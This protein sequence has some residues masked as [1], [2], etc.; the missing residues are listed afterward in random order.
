[1]DMVNSIFLLMYVCRHINSPGYFYLKIQTMISK[2]AFN[3]FIRLINY[4]YISTLETLLRFSGEFDMLKCNAKDIRLQ[5][6]VD[7]MLK[8]N[9]TKPFEHMYFTLS[10]EQIPCLVVNE[11]RTFTKNVIA[12]DVLKHRLHFTIPSIDYL[13][14]VNNTRF[15]DIDNVINTDDIER[16][17]NE[18]MVKHCED[19]NETIDTLNF[20][21]IAHRDIELLVPNNV[22]TKCIVTFN[23]LELIDLFRNGLCFKH[24]QFMRST[25]H[26]IKDTI[27]TVTSGMFDSVGPE[28][29]KCILP[30][31]VECVM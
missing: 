10:I 28:C 13:H 9:I 15:S 25:T 22:L 18:R 14:Q 7:L 8:H 21:G 3:P 24:N 31:P 4:P 12:P 23:G 2:V 27:S 26:K 19:V 20:Q 30:K 29:C 17:C 11:L 6:I 1:M 16:L 5:S